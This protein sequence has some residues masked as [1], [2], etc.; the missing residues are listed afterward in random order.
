MTNDEKYMARCIELAK[1]GKCTTSPNPMVGAVIVCDGKIIGEGYHI[2]CGGPHAEVN[3]INSVKEQELLRKS[4]LYVSLEPCSHY[5]KTPP[6]ADLIIKKGIPKVVIGCKDPFPLVAGHGIEKLTN[7]G[8]EVVCGVLENECILLNKTF[9]CFNTMKRPY[10]TLKWAQSADGYI[11]VKRENGK[12]AMISNELTKTIVHKYR[13]E[14]QSIMVGKN[15]AL[16]D[17]PSLTTRDGYGKNPIR[18]VLDRKLTLPK[19][20]NIFNDKADTI[21]FNELEDRNEGNISF[22]KID[23]SKNIL[24]EVLN[25]LYE[26][27][28]E[29][30]IVEGGKCLLQSFV[31]Y[32]LWD[33]AFIEISN[34]IINDGIEAPSIKKY[35]KR[36]EEIHFNREIIHYINSVFYRQ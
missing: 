9:I 13:A 32:G 20:L 18:L 25:T 28:I 12:P 6:C 10:V 34:T 19:E 5:G 8:I 22:I 2:R 29:S 24:G 33:E 17:N 4:T 16:L 23:Y 11:D 31:D 36:N 21:I 14:N 26:K 7:A 3:A 1:N 35:F 15:T 30:V 27:K